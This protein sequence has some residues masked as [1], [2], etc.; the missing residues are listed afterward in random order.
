MKI[1]QSLFVVLC[2]AATALMTSVPMAHAGTLEQN[3]AVGFSDACKHVPLT[4]GHTQAYIAGYNEGLAQCSSNTPQQPVQQQPPNII[5]Q[6]Q[7]NQGQAQGQ[8]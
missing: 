2:I 7:Q 1:T 5:I 4:T 6:N 3:R 8:R